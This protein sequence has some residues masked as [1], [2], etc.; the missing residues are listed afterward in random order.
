MAEDQ[1]EKT[2]EATDTRREDFRKRGQVA[3][4]RE[5]STALFFLLM[6]MLLYVMGRF[7]LQNLFDVF[8]QAMGGEFIDKLREG[9]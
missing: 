2:E 4:T 8:Q 7:F 9:H 6:S 5:L 1:G 3:M